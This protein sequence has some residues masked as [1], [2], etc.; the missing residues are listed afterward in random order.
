MFRLTSTDNDRGALTAALAHASSPMQPAPVNS[1]RTPRV[2]VARRRRPRKTI[3][4][5]DLAA[6]S[7]AVEGRRRRPVA[8]R[9]G[10]NF[11]VELE[12]KQLVARDQQTGAMKWQA[13]SPANSSAR[14]PMPS[15]RTSRTRKAS[16]GGSP[17]YDGASGKRLWKADADGPLGAPAAQG[18]IVYVPY[19]QQW[20]SLIDGKTGEQLA[21][22]RGIDEQSRCCA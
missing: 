2:F 18:G 17:R 3:V 13:D 7:D 15:A 6:A 14:P 12:G 21:R 19:I 5:Y 4:A 20:L 9:V 1:S 8:D 11:I 22:M 16:T 10:G